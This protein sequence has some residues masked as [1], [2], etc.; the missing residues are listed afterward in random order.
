M[1]RP[2]FLRVLLNS[3][4]FSATRLP[5][6]CLTLA[7]SSWDLRTLFSSISRVA[8]ASS[9]APCSSSFSCSSMR[10]CLSRG[11]EVDTDELTES[12]RVVISDSLS[13]TPGLQD[14]VGGNNL[15]LKRGLSLLPLAR[16]ADGGEVGND[17]LGVLSLSS[18][19][20]SSNQDGLVAASVGH[21]LVSSLS[22]G[23]DVGP[24]LIPPLANVQLHGA[25]GVDGESLVGVDG[26][27]EE[28]RVGVDELVLVSDN[29]VPQDTSITKIG[30]V[31]HVL[32]TVILRRVHLVKNLFLEHLHLTSNLDGDLV[33]ILGL[34]ETLQIATRGLVWDPVRLLRV[35]GLGLVLGLQLEGDGQPWR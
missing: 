31:S 24:A 17:L 25:E 22:N 19:R 3:S 9:R 20:L 15:L 21:A 35:I 28:T 18:T 13:I 8:S 33:A 30:E 32:S 14:R 26:D 1:A 27:T 6:S 16:G 10:L 5:I 11:V 23:E 34:D 7:S 12:R 4:S 2:W 29:R